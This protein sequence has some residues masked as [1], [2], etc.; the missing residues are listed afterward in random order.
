MY[1]RD[2]WLSSLTFGG[3]CSRV[4]LYSFGSRSS[5]NA[6]GPLESW[7]PRD[8]VQAWVSLV[9]FL[10]E[11]PIDTGKTFGS[12][13]SWKTPDDLA[14]LAVSSFTFPSFLPSCSW[15]T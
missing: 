14:T 10:S 6:R 5:S 12:W 13:Q 3:D 11:L 8:T 7:E 9:A 2:T 1:T 15:E 4:S